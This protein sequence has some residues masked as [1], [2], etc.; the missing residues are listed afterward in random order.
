MD[1][2]TLKVLLIDARSQYKAAKK[3]FNKTDNA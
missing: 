1:I 2:F 3:E